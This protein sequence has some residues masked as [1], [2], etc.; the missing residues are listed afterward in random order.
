[1]KTF[2]LALLTSIFTLGLFAQEFEVPKNYIL[3]KAEDYAPYEKDVVDCFN[4]L[5]ETPLNEQE[6][7]RKEANAF[8]LTWLSGSPEIEIELKQEIVTFMRTSPDLLMIFLGG[9]GIHSLE[10]RDFNDKVGGNLAG[11]EAAIEFYKKNKNFLSKDKYM[12]KYIKLQKNG[13]LK[14]YIEKNA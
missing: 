3:D 2:I 8:L 14:E 1:M 7:K 11:I 9:W 12:E 5:I 4:W 6:A 13:K 10:T